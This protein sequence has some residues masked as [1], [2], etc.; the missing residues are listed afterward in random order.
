[1]TT[2]AYNKEDSTIS[3][4]SR[5][6]RDSLIVTDEA[7]KY[8]QTDKGLFFGCGPTPG[9]REFIDEFDWTS[10]SASKDFGVTFFVVTDEGV[11]LTAVSDGEFWFNEV[12]CSRAIGSGE[13]FALAAMDYGAT[14]AEAVSY[15]ASR[16]VYTGGK[17]RT[18]LISTGEFYE[19]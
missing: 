5:V 13:S 6:T 3:C 12:S 17:V 16:D 2:I 11:F 19:D 10:K 1:M 9:I 8:Y 7:I 14:S 4:D 15:T 18:Y